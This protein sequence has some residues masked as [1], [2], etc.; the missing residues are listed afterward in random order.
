MSTSTAAPQRIRGLTTKQVVWGIVVFVLTLDGVMYCAH[1]LGE[2]SEPRMV[3][4][5]GYVLAGVGVVAGV[6]AAEYRR[7]GEFD[8]AIVGYRITVWCLFLAFW[9]PLHAIQLKEQEDF[10]RRQ[11]QGREQLHQLILRSEQQGRDAIPAAGAAAASLA[12]KVPASPR[13]PKESIAP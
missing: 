8:K 12:G 2:L 10:H 5:M 6:C 11:E 4:L 1:L 13:E 9:Q 3:T 7:R